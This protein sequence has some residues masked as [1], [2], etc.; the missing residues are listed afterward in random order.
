MFFTR[1]CKLKKLCATK[2]LAKTLFG[3]IGDGKDWQNATWLQTST[4]SHIPIRPIPFGL[5]ESCWMVPGMLWLEKRSARVLGQICV[6]WATSAEGDAEQILFLSGSFRHD[7]VHGCH[8]ESLLY[9]W[10]MLFMPALTTRATTTTTTTTTTTE[11]PQQ[12][13]LWMAIMAIQEFL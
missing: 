1:G 5:E 7:I 12:P 3:P 11:G 10:Q 13:R 9:G 4:D 2:P 6:G 8:M